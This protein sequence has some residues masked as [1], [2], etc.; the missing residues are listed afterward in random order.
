MTNISDWMQRKKNSHPPFCS[1][2]IKLNDP[3]LKLYPTRLSDSTMYSG[4]MTFYLDTL[5]RQHVIDKEVWVE[6][7]SHDKLVATGG[8]L[9]C[10]DGKVFKVDRLDLGI[11]LAV[12]LRECHI[13]LTSVNQ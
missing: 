2:R 3:F 11:L 4:I 8:E 10:L 12:D 9:G 7:G 6:L 1:N 13:A 5:A